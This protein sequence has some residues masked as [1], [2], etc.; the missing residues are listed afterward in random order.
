LRSVVFTVGGRRVGEAV[1]RSVHRGRAV[2]IFRAAADADVVSAGVVLV[3]VTSGVAMCVG[4]G[5]AV[6]VAVELLRVA[7]LEPGVVADETAGVGVVVTGADFGEPGGLVLRSVEEAVVVGWRDG[8]AAALAVG[9]GLPP[10]RG[11]GGV[12]EIEGGGVVLVGGFEPVVGSS[13]GADGLAGARERIVTAA[14]ESVRSGVE[15]DLFGGQ[16]EGGRPGSA[17]MSSP[18]YRRRTVCYSSLAS[19]PLVSRR[20]IC[21]CCLISTG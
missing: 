16:V 3:A 13:T 12:V 10:G 4:V 21:S 15:S 17:W 6:G 18:P 14:G 2:L 5:A 7:R 1:G 11:L 8:G 20:T 19:V 9:G